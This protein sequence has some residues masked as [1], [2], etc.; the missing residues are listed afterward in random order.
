M[1]SDNLS[2]REVIS[3]S[4]ERVMRDVILTFDAMVS[5]L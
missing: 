1:A 3:A 5:R 2:R 4:I